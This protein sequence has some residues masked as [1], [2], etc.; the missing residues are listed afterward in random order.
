MP[1]RPTRRPNDGGRRRRPERLGTTLEFLA[2]HVFPRMNVAK[3]QCLSGF[4]VGAA[5]WVLLR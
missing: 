4:S 5:K 2:R 1:D 3:W